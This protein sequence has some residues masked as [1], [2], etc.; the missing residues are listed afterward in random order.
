MATAKK[1]TNTVTLWLVGRASHTFTA[2][3]LRRVLRGYS[4]D[5]PKEEA[6]AILKKKQKGMV[7]VNGSAM[8][9]PVWASSAEAAESLL[10]ALP[11]ETPPAVTGESALE[12]TGADEGIDVN[13]SVAPPTGGLNIG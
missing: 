8:T 10:G 3:G 7:R 6:A 1:N 11:T 2:G 12:D 5:L 9:V 13:T 4:V